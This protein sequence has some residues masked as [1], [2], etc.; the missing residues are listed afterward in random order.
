MGDS[1]FHDAIYNTPTIR[2]GMILKLSEKSIMQI[3]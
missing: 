2:E 3:L 1:L